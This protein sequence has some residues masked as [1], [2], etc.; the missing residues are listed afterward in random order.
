MNETDDQSL[1]VLLPSP[2]LT[3][4]ELQTL[5]CT[6]V[7]VSFIIERGRRKSKVEGCDSNPL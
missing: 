6:P 7:T 4:C 1:L 3:Y 5:Y 2:I